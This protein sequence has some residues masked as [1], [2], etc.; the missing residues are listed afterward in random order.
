MFIAAATPAV[1]APAAPAPTATPQAQQARATCHGLPVTTTAD[2]GEITGT[3][4]R[5]VIRLKGPGHVRSGAGADIICGSRFA[6]V[7]AAGPGDDVVIGGRGHDRIHGGAGRDVLFGEGGN[8]V[9]HGGRGGDTLVGGAGRN[10]VVRDGTAHPRENGAAGGGDVVLPG[11]QAISIITDPADVDDLMFE[12]ATFAFDWLPVQGTAGG[13]GGLTPIWQTATPAPRTVMTVTPG[14]SAFAS[15]TSLMPDMLLVPTT[16]AAAQ[17]GTA[18]MLSPS[19]M[20]EQVGTGPRDGVSLMN[21]TQQPQTMGISLTASSPWGRINSPAVA[22]Q[23]FPQAQAA[24][25]QPSTLRVRVTQ[26]LGTHGILALPPFPSEPSAT[27]TFTPTQPTITLRYGLTTG[28][29]Q[30]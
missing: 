2:R 9:L 13:T 3:A 27:G 12:N 4:R 16:T 8:D 20:F 26:V 14:V 17:W 22:A 29:T 24:F 18:M 7:I 15:F 28:F 11:V 1:A 23:V 30:G 10:R 21:V 6:D 25:L 19:Y 5:D